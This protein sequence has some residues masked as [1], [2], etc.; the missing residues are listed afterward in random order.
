MITNLPTLTAW[1]EYDAALAKRDGLAADARA[2]SDEVTRLRQEQPAAHAADDQAQAAAVVA[3]AKDPGR[4]ASEKV[5]ADLEAAEH[6]AKI[7]N[8][9]AEAQDQAVVNLLHADLE[10]ARGAADTARQEAAEAYAAAVTALAAARQT[11]YAATSVT[12][13]LNSGAR[14]AWKAAGSPGLAVAGV[15][16]AN[17]EP[18]A[19][20][21]LL[22][23]LR[24]ESEGDRFRGVADNTPKFSPGTDQRGTATPNVVRRVANPAGGPGEQ[25]VYSVPADEAQPLTSYGES[26]EVA[27]AKWARDKQEERDGLALFAQANGLKAAPD[28]DALADLR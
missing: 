5:K 11:Y 26:A 25:R 27:A 2:A 13:W 12:G 17:G 14:R 8:Q 18:V 28:A 16:T 6:K 21:R 24:A 19:V 22:A 4:R 9:A 15:V 20:D 3:G 1:P 23:A 10:T 7:L